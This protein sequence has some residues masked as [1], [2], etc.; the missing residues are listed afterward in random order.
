VTRPILLDTCALLWL[1][2]GDRLSA[3]A[4][5]ALEEADADPG[6]VMVS[7]ISSWEIGQLAARGRLLLPIEPLAWFQTALDSGLVLAPMPP[8]V[9]VGSSFLPGSSLR[10]PA[11]RI[12]AATARALGYRLMTRD[13]P[14]LQLAAEGHI[15]AIAC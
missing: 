4:E 9:L 14:L 12:I 10:D 7:P 15:Q 13:R 5:R 6:C 11:D 2:N 1:G 3:P 8:S